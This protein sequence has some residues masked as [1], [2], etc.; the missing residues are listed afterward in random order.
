MPWREA[1][2]WQYLIHHSLFKLFFQSFP[3]KLMAMAASFSLSHVEFE[4][5]EANK[6]NGALY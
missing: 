4:G 1:K 6:G 5:G 3:A 2:P